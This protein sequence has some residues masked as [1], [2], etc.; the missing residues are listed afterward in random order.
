MIPKDYIQCKLA[1]FEYFRTENIKSYLKM[2]NFEYFRTENIK[3]YLK[4]FKMLGL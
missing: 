1:N 3:S 4:M 2:F